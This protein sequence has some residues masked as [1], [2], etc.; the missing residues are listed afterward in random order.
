MLQEFMGKHII[1]H[2]VMQ[3]DYFYRERRTNERRYSRIKSRVKRLI[4][5]EIIYDKLVIGAQN[6]P[7]ERCNKTKLDGDAG[8]MLPVMILLFVRCCGMAGLNV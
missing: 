6:C 4:M 5:S 7:E 2:I 3:Q 1:Y 8:L